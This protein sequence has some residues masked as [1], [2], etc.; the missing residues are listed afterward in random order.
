M[1]QF[2][3]VAPP[4]A[5]LASVDAGTILSLDFLAVLASATPVLAPGFFAVFDSPMVPAGAG[6]GDLSVAAAGSVGVSCAVGNVGNVGNVGG[7]SGS[8][9]RLVFVGSACAAGAA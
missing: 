2:Q 4:A 1:P 7:T 8:G 3:D 6:S 5:S 9:V